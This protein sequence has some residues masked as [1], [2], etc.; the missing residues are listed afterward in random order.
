MGLRGEG[1]KFG[2]ARFCEVEGY[3]HDDASGWVV[4]HVDS[5]AALSFCTEDVFVLPGWDVD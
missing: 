1:V 2:F 4:E 3:A 5:E